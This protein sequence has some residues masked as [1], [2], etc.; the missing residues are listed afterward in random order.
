MVQD[1]PRA[2][3]FQLTGKSLGIIQRQQGTHR[4]HRV[5]PRGSQGAQGLNPGMGRIGLIR[6][7]SRQPWFIRFHRNLNPHVALLLKLP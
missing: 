1:D 5:Q 2:G 3:P 4:R 6:K 7:G